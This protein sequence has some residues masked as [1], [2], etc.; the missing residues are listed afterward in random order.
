LFSNTYA[1]VTVLLY[2]SPSSMDM[3]YQNLQNNSPY[4]KPTQKK[5]GVS[6][7]LLVLIII[8]TFLFAFLLFKNLGNIG[9]WFS[10]A[11]TT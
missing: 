11:P 2:F 5:N 3:T 10:G 6:V 4:R 7:W 1:W 9:G 8:I